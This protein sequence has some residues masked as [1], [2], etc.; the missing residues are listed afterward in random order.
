M[1]QIELTMI[2]NL[3]DKNFGRYCLRISPV[4]NTEDCINTNSISVNVLETNTTESKDIKS[5]KDRMHTT[6]LYTLCTQPQC[7]INL[8]K[9]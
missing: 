7:I 1:T 9:G 3:K 4:V 2:M 8:P 5:F 6:I